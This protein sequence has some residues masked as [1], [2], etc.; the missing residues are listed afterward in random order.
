MFVSDTYF[1]LVNS[2]GIQ[3][4]SNDDA[5]GCGQGSQITYVVP[6]RAGCQQYTLRQGCYDANAC[7]GT[8]GVSVL[9]TASPTSGI[10]CNMYMHVF[11]LPRI[12]S[13]CISVYPH[14]LIYVSLLILKCIT[15]HAYV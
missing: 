4:V 13:V 3:V 12:S 10:Y 11:N 1:V 14:F 6:I 2:S 8:T 7:N 9:G 15:T 5:I